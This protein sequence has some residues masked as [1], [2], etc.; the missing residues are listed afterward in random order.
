MTA[1]VNKIRPIVDRK[2]SL[3]YT[4]DQ[5]KFWIEIPPDENLDQWYYW[6]EPTASAVGDWW[7]S[8]DTDRLF[9]LAVTWALVYGSMIICEQP[10]PTPAGDVEL[11]AHLVHPSNFGVLQPNQPDLTRQECFCLTTYFTWDECV[12]RL[13]GHPKRDRILSRMESTNPTIGQTEGSII[14]G[15]G[16]PGT[17]NYRAVYD[18]A[19]PY[20]YN[21]QVQTQHYKWHDLYCYDDRANDWQVFTISG[22]D[23]IFDR[24]IEDI[25]L[26]GKPHFVKICPTEMPDYFWGLSLVETVARLQEWYAGRFSELDEVIGKILRP[27]KAGLG[28]GISFEEKLA[29][30]NRAGGR[31]AFPSATAKIQEFIP[32]VPPQI[33]DYFSEVDSFFNN[34][35]GM[36]PNL[37]GQQESGTRTAEMANGLLRLAGSELKRESSTVEKQAEDTADTLLHLQLRYNSDPLIDEN[38]N[39]FFLANFPDKFRIRVDGHSTSSLFMEDQM[40]KANLLRKFGDITPERYVKMIH[41]TM[42]GGIVHDLKKIQYV[43]MLSQKVAQKLQDLKRGGPGGAQ[44][45]LPAGGGGE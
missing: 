33:F 43:N 36:S 5:V 2:S 8:T 40:E 41:P 27:P 23:I 9:G 16:N 32:S 42:E 35:S 6:L 39:P 19:G 7:W 24:P 38:G 25:G 15:P 10:T 45:A 29:S 3:I 22:P 17:T 14:M 44:K 4:P 37:W 31:A 13:A 12:R 26:P 20:G 28:L 21:A 18:Y 1:R 34:A 11:V 30:L